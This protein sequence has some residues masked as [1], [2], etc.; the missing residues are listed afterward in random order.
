MAG[1]PLEN[2]GRG[3]RI[4]EFTMKT[5]IKTISDTQQTRNDGWIAF[6]DLDPAPGNFPIWVS[7][8]GDGEYPSLYTTFTARRIGHTHW[9]PAHVPEPP[10]PP[11]RDEI[12]SAACVAAYRAQ[13][14][15]FAECEPSFDFREGWRKGLAYGRGVGA[16]EAGK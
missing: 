3:A 11:T 15:D 2:G 8:I 7:S 16:Q 12:D 14:M 13:S 9:R 4:T 5:R 6:N 10:R 1:W